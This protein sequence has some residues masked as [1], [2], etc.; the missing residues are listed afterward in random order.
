MLRHARPKVLITEWAT[1][2]GLSKAW[3]PS[4]H[5]AAVRVLHAPPRALDAD[6][7]WELDDVPSADLPPPTARTRDDVAC[8]VYSSGTGGDV[9]GCMLTHGNYL[10]QAESLGA[11]CS[12][13]RL[14]SASS[15]SCRRTTPSTS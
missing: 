3:D 15:A 14:A 13:W 11:L 5:D 10:A 1:W 4:A 12:R 8:I 9:K 2:R 7:R 6:L